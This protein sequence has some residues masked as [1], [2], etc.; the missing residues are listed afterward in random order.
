[1]NPLRLAAAALA[2]SAALVLLP[3]AAQA[4]PWPKEYA[5]LGDSYASGTGAGEYTDPQCLR[6]DLAY[7]RLLAHGLGADL[8]FA[9]CSGATTADLLAEQLGALDAGTDLVTVSIGGNDIGWT[10]AVAACLTPLADCAD[11]IAA[12]EALIR[13]QLPALLDGAYAAIADRAPSA[14]V[15]VLGY[16]RLF[17][18]RS[19]CGAL[20][21]PS[22]AE[23]VRMNQAADLLADVLGEAAAE[24]DFTYVDVRDSFAGHAVCDDVPYL[25]GLRYP[26]AESYHPNAL[27]HANGYYPAVARAV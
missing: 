13:Y 12:S 24:H 14:R 2:A 17:N 11:E 22:L 25:H 3:A 7:P 21:Q 4:E 27:G 15:L 23:Q 16:P 26:A 19:T 6:S 9:A 18:E 1:M 8:A 5:A 20:H 10:E